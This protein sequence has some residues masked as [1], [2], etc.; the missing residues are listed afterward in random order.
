MFEITGDDIAALNDTDLATLI[1]RL[2][3]AE[4]R[5]CGYPTVAVTQ[6]GNQNAKD[7]GVDVRVRLPVGSAIT[8][9]VPRANTG[10][11]VKKPDMPRKKIIK[12]MKPD[13]FLRPA[14]IE[15]AEA[16]GAYIIVSSGASTSDTALDERLEAMAEAVTGTAAESRIHVDFFD[17]SRVAT[18]VRD[19]AGM[20][21]W[22]RGRIGKAVPGWQA[23]GS[24]SRI[25]EGSDP[26]Y[27]ADNQA[28]IR[29]AS[30]DSDADGVRVA[31]GIDLIRKSLHSPGKVVRLIGLSGVGKTRLAEALFDREIGTSALDP[32]LAIYTDIADE[33]NPPPKTMASDLN[34]SGT[35]AILIVDN[36]SPDLHRQLA[37]VTRQTGSAISLLTIE[38]DIRDDE[39]EG[40][41]VFS[42]DVASTEMIDRLIRNR[43][44]DLSSIDVST[45][46]E[47]SG[48]NA[49][50]ALALASRIEKTETVVGLNHEEL[51]RRLFQQRHDP[52]PLLLLVAQVCS[53]VYSFE[54][55]KLEGEG[56]ELPAFGELVGRSAHDLYGALAELKRRDLLQSRAE[57]RA[58]LPHA[59]ANRL[60]KTA[61]Q[62]FPPARVNSIL[63]EK[64][65]DRIRRSFSRRLGYLDDSKEA[66]ALATGWLLPGGLL[67]D[68][69][70]LTELERTMF[71]N[72]APLVP[73]TVMTVLE[74][75]FSGVDDVTLGHNIGFARLI[76]SLAYEEKYFERSVGLLVPFA[77]L[78]RRPS[79]ENVA[80]IVESLFFVALSGTHAPIDM[81]IRVA[82]NLL[83]SD[84][85]RKRDLGLKALAA[86]LKT[87]HFSSHY[88]FEFGARSRDY[89]YYP[90]TDEDAEDW[91]AR[92]IALAE[93]FALEPSIC[94]GEVRSVL[95]DAFKE[96]WGLP[97]QQERLDML[98]RAIRRDAFWRE[99][100]IATRQT[101]LHGGKDMPSS[102]R[103]RLASLESFLRPLDLLDRVRAAVIGVR[104][105]GYDFEDL[106]E[107]D[108][109]EDEEDF[110]RSYRAQAT[111]SA[112]TIEQLAKDAALDPDTLA[113]LL[114]EL[115]SADGRVY[116]FGHA[117]AANTMRLRSLWDDS[118]RALASASIQR[119]AFLSGFL[120]GTYEREPELATA[121][122][123]EAVDDPDLAPHFPQLQ[124]NLPLDA[125][126][127]GRLHNSLD[128]GLAPI[129]AYFA[130]A[131]GRLSD[132][133]PEITEMDLILRIAGE[134]GGLPIATEIIAT[135]LFSNDSRRTEPTATLVETGR[136]LLDMFE[137][138]SSGDQQT[139]LDHDLGRIIRHSLSGDAGVETA[140]KLARKFI[141]A[142]AGHAIRGYDFDD[143][144]ENLLKVQP[145]ATLDELFP[146]EAKVRRAGVRLINTMARHEKPALGSVPDDILFAWVACEPESRFP[147]A[148]ATVKLFARSSPGAH[149]EWTP[150]ALRL[151][152]EAPDRRKVFGE[153]VVRLRP[154]IWSG[155]L[156]TKLEGR[157]ELL[158]TLPTKAD[159]GLIEDHE[160][161]MAWLRRLVADERH[162]EAQENL[163]RNTRF[164]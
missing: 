68:V 54:G 139:R 153:I 118:V 93:E 63:V 140:R 73:D 136:R 91:F 92:A 38:Y 76:R 97:E 143:V 160:N 152:E 101:L 78:R 70:S 52:D 59:I 23:F 24:W 35:R 44:P 32:S 57:W 86:L 17:R 15:L 28:R 150:L 110:S 90:S 21:V 85:G 83:T 138:P 79:D 149:H 114:P 6:G 62:N 122:L 95:A 69:T 116:A 67:A 18:W 115:L 113:I 48:G 45:V 161:A 3:E 1:G 81:R 145:G 137:F 106:D 2:C 82:R 77:M 66:R 87:S 46:A 94:T 127:F 131:H 41:E 9:A 156:A 144:C 103:D 132:R 64:A 13:G 108:L 42:L 11:Q 37:D 107:T 5:R 89:G 112:E 141:T 53:L 135:R 34:A 27:L 26:A 65:S 164:E 98:A 84:D 158:R 19:H 10:Y 72:I 96:L 148:A 80:D 142:A 120:A 157:L 134:P 151:L 125:E 39:P 14:L 147:L 75:G 102:S 20:I 126:G 99:G 61:L 31:D 130:L 100:W 30:H 22:V 71:T 109:E 162:R 105:A 49:R 124:A 104:G 43:Y 51:F 40:T 12:E 56:A 25:P 33:P 50:I 16:S 55:E 8:G 29:T 36:C 129:E 133:V 159:P 47:F 146:S 121:I 155:S 123:E 163:S 74:N 117:L 60:A 128:R 7:G 154:M 58:I 111:R 4:L 119:L 88:E